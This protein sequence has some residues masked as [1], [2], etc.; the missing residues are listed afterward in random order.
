MKLEQSPVRATRHWVRGLFVALLLTLLASPVHAEEPPLPPGLGSAPDDGPALPSG[1]NNAPAAPSDEPPLPSGLSE[2]SQAADG[3]DE[4]EPFSLPLDLHGFWEAR[5]GS[6]IQHD[7]H[8]KE[9]SIAETRLQLDWQ[10]AISAAML[11]LKGDFVYDPVLD[12]HEIDLERG[13][14][15]FDLRE[16]NVSLRPFQ[17][18]DMKIGRQILTWGTGDLIF[19]NDLFPKDWNSFF[20]GRDSE[21]LKAPSDA[22]KAS[23]FSRPANLDIVYS[24]RFDPDR[25]VD[26][27]RISYYNAMLGRRAGEDAIISPEIPDKW[28]TDDEIAARLFRNMGGYQAALYGYRG[29]WKSPGGMEPTTGRATFPELAVYGASLRGPTLGGIGNVEG[30]YYDSIEDRDGEDPFVNNSEFRF[31]TGYERELSRDFTA[32]VQY[33]IEF[34]MDHGAYR[35]SL[36]PGSEPRDED[37][38]VFTLRL[39]RLLMSQNLNLSLFTFYSPSD[40]DAYIRPIINYKA[41][42]H[43]TVETGGNI[44]LGERDDT[45]FGQFERNSNLYV[46]ARYNF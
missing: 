28:L 45:F 9:I 16:A 2:T 19:I 4:K 41:S 25:F 33:Y 38:H 37:R 12:R 10:R 11:N 3:A 6:R 20:I 13:E 26:G 42:D 36:P 17:F 43:W 40:N 8:E 7:P 32:G 29:F 18:L 30:G 5:F 15:W 31:L 22:I 23:F 14:G 39:T 44:F 24:P 34:M 35:R 1:L 46:G 27:R 21:Y